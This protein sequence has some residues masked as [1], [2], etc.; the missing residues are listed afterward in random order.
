MIGTTRHMSNDDVDPVSSPV[1]TAF[2]EPV[3]DP[4][5][6]YGYAGAWGC[7]S[8]EEFPFLHVGARYYDPGT[9]RF[10]QRDPIGI[11]GGLNVYEYVSSVPTLLVDPDGTHSHGG[12]GLHHRYK[13]RRRQGMSPDEAGQSLAN[14]MSREGGVGLVWAGVFAIACGAY[15]TPGVAGDAAEFIGYLRGLIK[16]GRTGDDGD[17]DDPDDDGGTANPPIKFAPP[18]KKHRRAAS[19]W[20]L[21]RQGPVLAPGC[22]WRG[23]HPVKAESERLIYM[24]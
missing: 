8:H 3:N 7:R 24:M 17:D 14:S 10:L 21:E 22:V 23:T 12:M 1:Y 13:G 11:R 5:T 15:Y 19:L 2:G 16:A 20:P 9:G 4:A 6:P 18:P